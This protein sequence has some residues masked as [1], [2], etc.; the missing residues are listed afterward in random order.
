MRVAVAFVILVLTLMSLDAGGALDPSH[1]ADRR[2]SIHGRVFIGIG[3]WWGPPYPYYWWNYPSPYY[4]PPP[5]VVYEPAPIYV[6]QPLA[7]LAQG[8]W[9]YCPSSNA[10]Y[11]TVPACPEAW[12]QVPPRSE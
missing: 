2:P 6:E 1:A 8:Y 5:P 11:P 7:P 3:P 12:M 4:W 9:Y 10:Y